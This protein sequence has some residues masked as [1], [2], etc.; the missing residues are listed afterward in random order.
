M[1]WRWR[2]A[3]STGRNGRQPPSTCSP[4]ASAGASSTR[5]TA[6]SASCCRR[7]QPCSRSSVSTIG[8]CSVSAS[9]PGA[10][11]V[12]GGGG[13]RAASP[14][15]PSSWWAGDRR[16]VAR[17]IGRRTGRRWR[18]FSWPTARPV[19]TVAVSDVD[20]QRVMVVAIVDAPADVSYTCRTTLSDGIVVESEAWRPGRR[21]LARPAPGDGEV[22]TST[23][24][25]P[26]RHRLVA[27]TF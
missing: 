11:G 14:R 13:C 4:A 7:C 18:R 16:L 27:A 1:R 10:A 12:A 20:G 23:S 9:A 15:L 17:A 25:S 3:R 19:G 2:W 8:C 22:P 5:S 24:S 21:C 6:S 26:D